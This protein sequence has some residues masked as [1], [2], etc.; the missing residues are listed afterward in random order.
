MECLKD[1]GISNADHSFLVKEA[2][3]FFM[4]ALD[5]SY[6]DDADEKVEKLIAKK[7]EPKIPEEKDRGDD[8][9]D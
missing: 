2:G 6:D 4:K 8:F 7:K 1:I 5:I 9:I 3:E